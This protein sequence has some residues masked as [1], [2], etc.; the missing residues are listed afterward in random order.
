MSKTRPEERWTR[1]VIER[2]VAFKN[3][4]DFKLIR[5]KGLKS[6]G[7]TKLFSLEEWTNSFRERTSNPK[8]MK[9]EEECDDIGKKYG[10]ATWTVTM[11]CLIKGYKPEKQPFVMERDWPMI[12]IVTDSKDEVFINWLAYLAQRHG[13]YLIVKQGAYESTYIYGMTPPQDPLTEEQRP[14]SLSAFTVKV[15]TPTG[16]PPEAARNLQKG[17][18]NWSENFGK[19]WVIQL[20]KGS[21]P[22]H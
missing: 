5:R 17:P 7:R 12:R 21:A 8:F 1:H 4:D 22:R 10:L 6:I 19:I 13:I 14:S 9:W 11:P 20:L 2:F 16:Y 18:P 3:S 15:E